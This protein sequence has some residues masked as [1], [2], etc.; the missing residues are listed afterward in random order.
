VGSPNA[1]FAATTRWF[2]EFGGGAYG[3]TEATRR[4]TT[5]GSPHFCI[6]E[7]P[8]YVARA[9]VALAADPEVGRF[10]GQT[11]S[12]GPGT[13]EAAGKCKVTERD[14]IGSSLDPTGARG[15]RRV[16]VRGQVTGATLT[17]G[18]DDI[19]LSAV[20]QLVDR[21]HVLGVG[22]ARALLGDGGLDGPI[23]LAEG[24]DL[25]DVEIADRGAAVL[26]H[27]RSEDLAVPR[28]HEVAAALD[29]RGSLRVLALR[30][31]GAQAGASFSDQV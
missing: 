22:R 3:V 20:G 11:L 18:A 16:T 2:E 28:R 27:G 21:S 4:E 8:T 6:S 7:S 17:F 9:V 24:L 15:K 13:P 30:R 26:T 25:L 29:R 10:S 1:A 23:T 14:R 31:V 19:D 12:S 5:I